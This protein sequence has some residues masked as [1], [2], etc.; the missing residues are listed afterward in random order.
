MLA[1]LLL[2]S[3][4]ADAAPLEAFLASARSSNPDIAA[5]DARY[6]RSRAGVDLARSALLPQITATAGYQRNFPEVAITLP[7]TDTTVNITPRDQIVGQGRVTVPLVVPSAVASTAAAAAQRRAEDVTRELTTETVL[8]D[9]VGAYYDARAAA[10][11]D[12][13]STT[14]LEAAE[15]SLEVARARAELDAAST[16]DVRRAEADVARARQARLAAGASL[17]DAERRLRTLSG[18]DE[19]ADPE[20]PVRPPPTGDLEARALESSPQLVTATEALEAARHGARAAGLAYSP[21][22]AGVGVLNVTNATGFS[23][24]PA[25]GNVGV[26]VSWGIL[27]GG[28]R[29][30]RWAQARAGVREAEARLE[31]LRRTVV[32]SVAS[33]SDGV[34]TARGS[35]EAAELGLQ[36]A[37]EGLRLAE[38]RYA[39]GA[40]DANALTLARRDAFDAEVQAARAEAGLAVAT[41]RLRLLVGDAIWSP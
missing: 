5:A 1:A 34:E 28:A 3:P 23:G 20:G 21:T 8:L 33:A 37:R 29:E 32:D 26:Q 15:R 12:R 11:V 6:D 39:L 4:S 36:A 18:L 10:R 14:G 27:D 7:G 38:E 40:L 30:S 24:K 17:R 41:E 16:L 22:V 31:G 2:L 35:V 13:A 9:V 19:T 25:T